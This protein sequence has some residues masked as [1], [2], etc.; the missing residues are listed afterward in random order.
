MRTSQLRVEAL[1]KRRTIVSHRSHFLQRKLY[2][3]IDASE[4][5]QPRVNDTFVDAAI[6]QFVGL[7]DPQSRPKEN[8]PFFNELP[9]TTG[10]LLGSWCEG[11]AMLDKTAFEQVPLEVVQ[12]LVAEEIK[13]VEKK[14]EPRQAICEAKLPLIENSSDDKKRKP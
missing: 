8:S 11:V 7:S 3:R 1:N 5:G 4:A 10:S 6:G 2:Y 12:K 14:K 9:R 13:R